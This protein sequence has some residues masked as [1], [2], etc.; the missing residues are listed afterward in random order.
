MFEHAKRVQVV[1][2]AIYVEERE[3]GSPH[4]D[5][6]AMASAACVEVAVRM[7]LQTCDMSR[8]EFLFAVGEHFDLVQ[9]DLNEKRK[10]E[11]H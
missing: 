1:A 6:L 5:A 3:A 11:A 7:T 10:R 8:E 2:Q 9:A 4:F